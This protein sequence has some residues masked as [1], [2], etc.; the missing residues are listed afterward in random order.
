MDSSHLTVDAYAGYKGEETPR[1]FTLDGRKL[2]VREVVDRWYSETHS[3]FRVHANDGQQYV[4]RFDLDED[5][6]EL[7]MQERR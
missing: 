3:Y 1:S 4:L 5:C 2:D 7:V 6:W